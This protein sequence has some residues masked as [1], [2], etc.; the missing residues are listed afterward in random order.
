MKSMFGSSAKIVILGLLIITCIMHS[1][2]GYEKVACDI[3]KNQIMQV[4]INF[5][6]LA[7]INTKDKIKSVSHF[8]QP[9]ASDNYYFIDIYTS[10]L[11]RINTV[12]YKLDFICIVS[13]FTLYG[14]F[15]I[16][17]KSKNIYTIDEDTLRIVNWDGNETFKMNLYENINNGYLSGLNAQFPPLAHGDKLFL[18]LYAKVNTQQR[19]AFANPEF[20]SHPIEAVL[21]LKTKEIETIEQVYPELNRRMC[22]GY[23]YLPDRIEIN[24]H[25]HGYTFPYS[26]SLFI[27]DFKENIKRVQFFGVKNS[28]I[29]KGIP[30]E[31]TPLLNSKD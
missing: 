1:C 4:Y 11:W 21:N 9:H 8:F 15:S 28:E 30:F 18:H 22:Y 19:P 6:S 20:Y 5:D 17:E 29:K 3:D 12:D 2:S 23:H 13:P 16:D 24:E 14:I 7:T 31:K 25:T 10:K 26:D 27:Y